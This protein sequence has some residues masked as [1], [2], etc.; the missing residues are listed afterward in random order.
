MKL[1]ISG[2]GARVSYLI[3]IKK[4]IEENN[5]HI[6]KYSGASSGSIFIV[7]MACKID[8][9]TIVNEYSKLIDDKTMYENYKI[10]IIK[11]Y[12]KKV[13][14]NNCHEICT[15]KVFISISE[16]KF[17]F[18]KNRIISKFESKNHLI[19]IILASSSFP[20]VINK[21]LFYRLKDN[22]YL[23]GYF[24][25]NTPLLEKNNSKNQIIVK[26]YFRSIYDLDL[27]I[28]KKISQRMMNLGYQNMKN[29]FEKGETTTNFSISNNKYNTKLYCYLL[30]FL[31]IFFAVRRLI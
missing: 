11:K 13:L 31:I 14:P 24:S 17:P 7:L 10:D 29:F 4:Y 22:R 28:F 19:D 15:G 1:V 25:D 30:V 21:N 6:E 8:N 3:G 12:L 26:T 23:D 27:F 9:K 2:G 18:I 20:V 5:I 16:F